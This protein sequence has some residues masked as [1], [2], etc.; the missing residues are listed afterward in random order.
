M[1]RKTTHVQ[2]TTHVEKSM[3]KIEY[4]AI[5]RAMC[6]ADVKEFLFLSVLLKKIVKE[7][8]VG[9]FF[10]NFYFGFQIGDTSSEAR[11]NEPL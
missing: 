7:T 8:N 3:T 1:P 4:N 10:V 2:I 5:N 6:K 9:F 11:I